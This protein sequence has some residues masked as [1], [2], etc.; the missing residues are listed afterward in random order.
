MNEN[1][2]QP[3]DVTDADI[4]FGAIR[5]LLPAWDKIPSEF[6][7]RNRENKWIRM[8]ADWFFDGLKTGA[9]T[10]K[11]AVDLNKAI[12]HL[13]CIQGSFEPKHEHKQAAVAYLASLWFSDYQPKEKP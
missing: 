7:E 10:P 5:G 12:R 1:W 11:P 3:S 9:L 6:R 8:Q 4:A 13:Q 2:N